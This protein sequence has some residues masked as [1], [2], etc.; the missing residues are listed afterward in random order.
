M[1][2]GTL[3][4][5]LQ[6]Q[7][8]VERQNQAV[9]L[10]LASILDNL[11]WVGSAKFMYKSADEEYTHFAKFKDWLITENQTPQLTELQAV[12]L[13]Q[14]APDDIVAYFEAA[15]KL[16]Q[17]TTAKI[18]D[19][20]KVAVEEDGA[21]AVFLQWFLTEQAESEIVLIDILQVLKR[22]DN[23]LRVLWDLQFGD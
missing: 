13:L 18:N 1:I 7:A 6:E 5:R 23:Q 16:E 9:Y 17:E 12:N 20:Y 2:S 15:L 4:A 8:N 21:T 22:L 14:D 11:N 19:L 10:Q 3:T